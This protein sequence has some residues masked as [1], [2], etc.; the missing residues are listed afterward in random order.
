MPPTAQSANRRVGT[1]E[2][3]AI[4]PTYSGDTMQFVG[5]VAPPANDATATPLTGVTLYLFRSHDGE[6]HFALVIQDTS[7]QSAPEHYALEEEFN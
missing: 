1:R 6:D 2:T 7:E 5:Q 3:A 4:W